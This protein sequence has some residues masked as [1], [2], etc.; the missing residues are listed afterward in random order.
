MSASL[1]CSTP[2][3]FAPTASFWNS[4]RDALETCASDLTSLPYSRADLDAAANPATKPPAANLAT[5]PSFL[6]ASFAKLAMLV[7]AFNKPALTPDESSDI[8]IL[9]SLLAIVQFL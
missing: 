8:F 2:T 6:F 7:L 9:I 3:V 4:S 1:S 5:D